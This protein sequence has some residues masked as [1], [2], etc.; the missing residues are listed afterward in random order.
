MTVVIKIIAIMV[1]TFII[2][3][4]NYIDENRNYNNI[5]NNK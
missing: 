5:I 1:V 2:I 4:N 3:D